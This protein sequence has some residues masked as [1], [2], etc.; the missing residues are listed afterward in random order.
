MDYFRNDTEAATVGGLTIENGIGSASVYG[1]LTFKVDD[2]SLEQLRD[3]RRR[4]ADMESAL[5]S[6]IEEGA[7]EEVVV[8][9]VLETVPNPFG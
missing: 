4:L 1:S 5:A 2:A 8:V 9:P 3:L 7:F 6:A